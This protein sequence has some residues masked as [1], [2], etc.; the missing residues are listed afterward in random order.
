MLALVAFRYR[1]QIMAVIQVW[2]MFKKMGQ[3]NNKASK[4]PQIKQ[5]NSNDVQLV[6]CAKCGTWKPQNE[7]LK[8]NQATFY[9]SSK[10]VSE[11]V[12]VK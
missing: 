6:R 4:E 12:P 2:Q 11:A 3:A 9:C 8:F 7:A 1:R 5:K 10:C